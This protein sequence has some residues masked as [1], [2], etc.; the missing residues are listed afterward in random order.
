MTKSSEY[1]LEKGDCFGRTALIENGKRE[2][3][4]K[5][6]EYT[7]LLCIYGESY[8]DVLDNY[9]LK[10]VNERLGCLNYIPFFS[11]FNI[12]IYYF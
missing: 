7:S 5:T 11:K 2:E 10:N 8:R 9:V 4:V 1:Y 3:N 6:L 12:F